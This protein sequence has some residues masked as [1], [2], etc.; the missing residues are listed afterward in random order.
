MGFFMTLVNG[1]KP[2]SNVTKRFVLDVAGALDM[3]RNN[4]QKQPW[5]AIPS[6]IYTLLLLGEKFVTEVEDCKVVCLAKPVLQTALTA[7]IFL[8]AR[9]RYR[10]SKYL[11][12]RWYGLQSFQWIRTF[13]SERSSN[14]FFSFAN[15]TTLNWNVLVLLKNFIYCYINLKG[16]KVNKRRISYFMFLAIQIT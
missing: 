7:E 11:N 15:E 16:N 5:W 9:L 6:F 2:L 3:P 4:A 8:G 14:K 1:W 10:R 13:D 12:Y